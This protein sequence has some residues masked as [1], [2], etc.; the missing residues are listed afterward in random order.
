[1]WRTSSAG[2]SA[3]RTPLRR[4]VFAR[5]GYLV[6]PRGIGGAARRVPLTVAGEHLADLELR[7]VQR[8]DQT[9]Q[10]L[11]TSRS[12]LRV[13]ST[14][15]RTPL[16]RLEYDVSARAVPMA[17][18]QVHAERGAFVHLLTLASRVREV[19]GPSDLSKL[20]L[21]VGGGRFRP[22][23]E[24]VLE[25]VIRDCGVDAAD[26]WAV[27]IEESRKRWWLRQLR[28]AIRDQ[29]EDA[30]GALRGLGW[31]VSRDG[32]ERATHDQPYTRR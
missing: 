30:A 26:G 31:T 14:L 11:T 27:A 6:Q 16:L 15:E 8:V 28:A 23:L 25:F 2:R 18:W 4:S 20:H 22:G 32:A 10:Y 7:V 3:A 5:E 17:H 21:P 9:G 29:Q 24:N 1:M 12:E 13:C 19:R